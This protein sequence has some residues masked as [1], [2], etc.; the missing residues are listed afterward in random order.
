MFYLFHHVPKTAGTSCLD[1]FGKIFNVVKDYQTSITPEA[2]KHYR[3][4]KI[5][6]ARLGEGDIL[7]GHWNIAGHYLD[8]RYPRLKSLDVKR[9]TFLRDPLSTAKSGVRFGIKRQWFDGTRND[10]ALVKR[11]GY[12]QRILQCNES[13]Y[14]EVLDQYWFVGITENLQEGFDVLTHALQKPSILVPTENTTDLIDIHFSDA[15]VTEFIEK[16]KVDYLI[17]EYARLLFSRK[18][19]ELAVQRIEP[20]DPWS[21]SANPSNLALLSCSNTKDKA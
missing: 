18:A 4:N 5:L 16:S 6:L 9:I 1:A 3:R 14:R 2:L 12:F 11:A 19:V 10:Q 8:Q 7:C 13:N 20:S 17:Y 15:A 21:P